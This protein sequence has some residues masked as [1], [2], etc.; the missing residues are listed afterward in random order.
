VKAWNIFSKNEEKC[1]KADKFQF[2]LRS[3]LRKLYSATFFLLMKVNISKISSR[4]TLK[5]GFTLLEMVIVMGIIALIL[6][7][8]MSVMKGIG[9]GG[10]MQRVSSDF[11]TIGSAVDMYKINN[12]RYPTTGQGLD[13]LV[14]APSPRP[15]RWTQLAKKVP[16]DPWGNEYRYR[17]QGKIDAA[18]YEIYSIGKDKT[19]NTEDD[20]S[21]QDEF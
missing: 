19:E 2:N 15:K 17:E 9:A 8:A 5:R 1:E 13:S 4:V 7:G 16:L 12:G 11:G 6:G 3:N 21:S 18:S 10:E 20:L 14:N